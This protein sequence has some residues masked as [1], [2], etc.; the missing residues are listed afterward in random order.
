MSTLQK[1]SRNEHVMGHV[2][3][4]PSEYPVY[5]KTEILPWHKYTFLQHILVYVRSNKICDVAQ[6]VICRLL[7]TEVR[8][9]V[10]LRKIISE[11]FDLSFSANI[12][13]K[14]T[15]FIPLYL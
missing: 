9:K 12:P 15:E 11:Y 6:I 10:T 7:I 14:L 1:K 2:L 4:V 3:N 5:L 13:P 8:K